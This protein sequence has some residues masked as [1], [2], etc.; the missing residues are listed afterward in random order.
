MHTTHDNT[1]TTYVQEIEQ[2]AKPDIESMIKAVN[3]KRPNETLISSLISTPDGCVCLLMHAMNESALPLA[4]RCLQGCTLIFKEVINLCDFLKS[5]KDLL[6]QNPD[7]LEELLEVG[8]MADGIFVDSTPIDSVLALPK[9]FRHRVTLIS[10][11]IE[12]GANLAKATYPR[13]HGTTIFHIATE[14]AI[15]Q[16]K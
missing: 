9:D 4:Q 7:F 15:E 8:V 1:C 10:I 16:S 3:T 2:G 14:M 5:S 13:S 12:H 11:L 6:C